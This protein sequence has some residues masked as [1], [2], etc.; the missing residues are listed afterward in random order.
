MGLDRGIPQRDHSSDGSTDVL[1]QAL[2]NIPPKLQ[3]I[4]ASVYRGTT[5]AEHGIYVSSIAIALHVRQDG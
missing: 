5:V 3:R 1:H 2:L 4:R